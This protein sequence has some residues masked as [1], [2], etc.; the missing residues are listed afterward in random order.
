MGYRGEVMLVFKDRRH[1]IQHP[2]PSAPYK[3]GDRIG[4]L[5]II[6][7]PKIEFKLVDELSKTER[8]NGG[9]GSTN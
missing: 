8:G 7:Y 5:M 4:Q 2:F 3:V 6:P 1:S 9:F